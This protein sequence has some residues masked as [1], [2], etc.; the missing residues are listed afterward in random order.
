M[1]KV[2]FGVKI[3]AAREDFAAF[4]RSARLAEQ[5][6]FDA[7]WV[8]ESARGNDPYALL[9]HVAAITS[10]RVGIAVALLPLHDPA[11]VARSAATLDQLSGGRFTLAVGV[12]GERAAD[13]TIHGLDRRERGRRTDEMLDIIRQLWAGEEVHH[14][15][16]YY[17]VEGKLD[18]TPVQEP[19]PVLVGGR[20]GAS[21]IQRRVYERV[22]N[23]AQGWMPYIMSPA[24]YARGQ[25]SIAD[26]GGGPDTLWT[27]VA[28][29]NIA[30][31][32]DGGAEF[33]Y[34]ARQQ[35]GRGRN[36]EGPSPEAL[37][38]TKAFV[39]AGT[40]DFCIERLNQYVDLGISDICFN[41][42]SPP[43]EEDHQMKLLTEQVLP[44]VRQHAAARG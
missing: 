44:A 4:S 1:A 11:D 32:S 33:K 42:A 26:L 27:F 7:F 35:A 16:K 25:Q 12:G 9:A 2:S 31:G 5:Y 14:E 22:V 28:H 36:G 17:H 41:W 29:A 10:M 6:G 13:F 3:G 18:V 8:G 38:R 43:G 34:A 21:S 24:A 15:G 39:I 19:L 20:G 23:R 30:G 37:E 40:P